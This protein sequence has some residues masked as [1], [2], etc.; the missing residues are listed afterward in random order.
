MKRS[1]AKPRLARALHLS[2]PKAL[3]EQARRLLAKS[4]AL[5]KQMKKRI[6]D[7]EQRAAARLDAAEKIEAAD[8]AGRV[9]GEQRTRKLP[10]GEQRLP[11][12]SQGGTVNRMLGAE[13]MLAISKGRTRRDGKEPDA[14]VRAAHAK[15]LSL[16]GLCREVE[17]KVGRGVPPSGIS[18]ARR[19]DRPIDK[20]IAEAIEE[21]T[22][23]AATKKNWPKGIQ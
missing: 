16:R 5:K 9:T 8:D 7:L 12:R 17:R 1:R 21:L 10:D 23:F 11:D 14:L 2:S 22:G 13:H 19:G 20:D 6:D 15:K 4:E 3:R 18:M